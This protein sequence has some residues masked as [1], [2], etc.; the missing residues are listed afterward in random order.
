MRT[1][2]AEVSGTRVQAVSRCEIPVLKSYPSYRNVEHRFGVRT[3][4]Y[5]RVRKGIE[6]VTN[7][8]CRV[9]TPRIPL[10]K[11]RRPVLRTTEPT[12][13]GVPA[14]SSYRTLTEGSVGLCGRTEHCRELRYR[15]YRANTSG[16]LY[17]VPDQTHPSNNSGVQI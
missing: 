15:I 10:L 11:C 5:Q 7:H 2:V 3:E 9:N 14:S 6:A 12:E 8:V 4:P 13:C 16:I 1:E 17:Y